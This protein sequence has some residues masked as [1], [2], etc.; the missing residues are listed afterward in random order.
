MRQEDRRARWHQP[1]PGRWI[2]RPPPSW[3]NYWR[4]H[5][6]THCKSNSSAIKNR[7]CLPTALQVAA[8]FCSHATECVTRLIGPSLQFMSC[9]MAPS[10]P[11]WSASRGTEFVQTNR[12]KFG[13]YW[14]IWIVSVRPNTRICALVPYRGL[15]TQC[16]GRPCEIG[17]LFHHPRQ[18]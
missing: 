7:P 4:K 11:K 9:A 3:R 14:F 16:Q 2:I 13:H 8:K 5:T 17:I 6:G 18:K 1:R 15:T 12:C 10:T